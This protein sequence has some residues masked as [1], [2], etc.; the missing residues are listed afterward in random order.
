MSLVKKF[1]NCNLPACNCI[2]LKNRHCRSI[3]CNHHY[4]IENLF[5]Y[6][7]VYENHF[8]V[9][10]IFINQKIIDEREAIQNFREIY[11]HLYKI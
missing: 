7:L 6:F 11:V 5:Y 8:V 2:K 1:K 3:L 4:F 10:M 9:E